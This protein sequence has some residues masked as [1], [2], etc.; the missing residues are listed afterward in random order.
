M[1]RTADTD[2]LGAVG[3]FRIAL[4][5]HVERVTYH[6]ILYYIILYYIILYHYM[7]CAG[8]LEAVGVVEVAL[9]E[10]VLY[11]IIQ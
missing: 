11:T 10:H 6:I 5:Q 3:A 2:L 8:L 7:F 1:T 4:A 9:A